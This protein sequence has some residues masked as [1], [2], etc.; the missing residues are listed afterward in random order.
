MNGHAPTHAGWRAAMED[1]LNRLVFETENGGLAIENN[2]DM[3]SLMAGDGSEKHRDEA[4]SDAAAQVAQLQDDM[5]SGAFALESSGFLE[6]RSSMTPLQEWHQ[7]MDVFGLRRYTHELGSGV[8][9]TE[10]D[11]LPRLIS[12]TKGTG[13]AIEVEVWVG[14]VPQCCF[15][16]VPVMYRGWWES[17]NALRSSDDGLETSGRGKMLFKRCRNIEDAA[18]QIRDDD[19]TRTSLQDQVATAAGAGAEFGYDVVTYMGKDPILPHYVYQLHVTRTPRGYAIRRAQRLPAPCTSNAVVWL[20]SYTLELSEEATVDTLSALQHTLQENGCGGLCALEQKSFDANDDTDRMAVFDA[21]YNALRSQ[22]RGMLDQSLRALHADAQ[23][24]GGDAPHA[25]KHAEPRVG[26]D[27]VLDRINKV[28]GLKLPHVVFAAHPETT[29]FFGGKRFAVLARYFDARWL[30][31]LNVHQLN[32]LYERAHTQPFDVCFPG[33]KAWLEKSLMNGDSRGRD[34][35]PEPPAFARAPAQGL[36][37]PEITLASCASIHLDMLCLRHYSTATLQAREDPDAPRPAPVRRFAYVE[38]SRRYADYVG[39]CVETF[40]AHGNQALFTQLCAYE[41]TRALQRQGNH[42]YLQL[43][44]ITGAMRDSLHCQ[45]CALI[46]LGLAGENTATSGIFSKANV[47]EALHRLADGIPRDAHYKKLIALVLKED[48]AD[49]APVFCRDADA[50]A[51]RLRQLKNRSS[52][53]KVYLIHLYEREAMTTFVF[54]AIAERRVAQHLAGQTPTLRVANSQNPRDRVKFRHRN[55]SEQQN[56]ASHI[57]SGQAFINLNGSGGG[58]K[59]QCLKMINEQLGARNV[60]QC[61]FMSTH[62]QTLMNRVGPQ[63]RGATI[64]RIMMIH[65]MTCKSANTRKY[66]SLLKKSQFNL[67]AVRYLDTLFRSYR[68]KERNADLTLLSMGWNTCGFEDITTLVVEE[69]GVTNSQQL[70]SIM[71]MLYRCA[72]NFSR[73]ITAGDV[74]QLPSIEGDDIQGALIEGFGECRFSHVHRFKDRVLR[75]NA[76]AIKKQVTLDLCAQN[77]PLFAQHAFVAGAAR[78]QQGGHARKRMRKIG[79]GSAPVGAQT[80]RDAAAFQLSHYQSGVFHVEID[81]ECMKQACELLIYR[82]SLTPETCQFIMRTN[83]EVAAM[84]RTIRCALLSTAR[85]VHSGVD[86]QVYALRNYGTARQIQAFERAT[87]TGSDFGHASRSSLLVFSQGAYEASDGNNASGPQSEDPV[88]RAVCRDG[89]GASQYDPSGRERLDA[90]NVMVAGQIVQ[91]TRNVP[92][93]D[94]NNLDRM[95]LVC[96]LQVRFELIND[97][98]DPLAEDILQRVDSFDGFKSSS[99]DKLFDRATHVLHQGPAAI[100]AARHMFKDFA[101]TPR[102]DSAA[103]NEPET[104]QRAGFA[105]PASERNQT[106]ELYGD[107]QWAM[108]QLNSLSAQIRELDV[109]RQQRR[110]GGGRPRDEDSEDADDSDDDDRTP[111]ETYNLEQQE[112]ATGDT[113]L[114]NYAPAHFE[115]AQGSVAREHSWFTPAAR[116]Y[117]FTAIACGTVS[118]EYAAQLVYTEC[119]R[120]CELNNTTCVLCTYSAPEHLYL[121]AIPEDITRKLLKRRG[122]RKNRLTTLMQLIEA[123]LVKVRVVKVQRTSRWDH[124][125]ALKHKPTETPAFRILVARDVSDIAAQEELTRWIHGG[126][127]QQQWSEARALAMLRGEPSGNQPTEPSAAARASDLSTVKSKY[128]PY[129]GDMCQLV[130]D[131]ACITY[132]AMQGAQYP[133]IVCTVP[134]ASKFCTFK[135]IYSG[136]TRPIDRLIYAG[137]MAAIKRAVATD[138]PVRNSDLGLILRTLVNDALELQSI[139]PVNTRAPVIAELAENERYG[140]LEMPLADR[141]MAQPGMQSDAARSELEAEVMAYE[142]EHRTF[143]AERVAEVAAGRTAAAA[144]REGGS[145]EEDDEEDAMQLA[146]QLASDMGFLSR[147]D[148]NAANFL[149]AVQRCTSAEAVEQ[150]ELHHVRIGVKRTI[151]HAAAAG[152]DAA[153]IQ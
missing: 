44:T 27:A 140:P 126:I 25:G 77:I 148:K 82:L 56:V 51:R 42:V 94:I 68:E 46:V 71:W 29:R 91:T 133:T 122:L 141:Y 21:V 132:H 101:A 142:R 105:V 115:R 61:S 31:K 66:M 124:T 40:N 88:D 96:C 72:P 114:N 36:F 128:I 49:G 17:V 150:Q 130:C 146:E 48:G 125:L 113:G 33:K 120:R 28:D 54:R 86:P 99:S 97:E 134:R 143:L 34:G 53:V 74:N 80:N 90:S 147:I 26:G 15:R 81:P 4:T 30:G 111:G 92:S 9:V 108:E 138:D 67:R 137:S 136:S 119:A 100:A 129:E 47:L 117:L 2:H 121:D 18:R 123:K 22:S 20:L 19:A 38:N 116:M 43:E 16:G 104:I 55:C 58:G 87:T 106:V 95:Q 127:T 60:L 11:K 145:G 112:A 144:A 57:E 23:R 39:D 1:K 151:N 35:V 41:L 7:Y 139:M 8:S 73:V 13:A 93:L 45:L 118:L 5:K 84:R 76:D 152:A 78:V 109:A 69:A 64:H 32:T 62:K 14:F 98:W 65:S 50:A 135:H 10:F 37:V 52:H 63:S 3:S 59:T 110:G 85:A 70:I 102:G 6:S 149:E 24:D 83:A 103:S 107:R 131:G 89:G 153:G 75:S 79:G 12:Q